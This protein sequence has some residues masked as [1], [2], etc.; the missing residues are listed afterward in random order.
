MGKNSRFDIFYF[1]HK[2]IRSA[3]AQLQFRAG[4]LDFSVDEFLS[5][6]AEELHSLWRLLHLHA[7]G[8]DAFVMPFLKIA[9]EGV[10]NSLE[11]DH[12]TFLPIMDTIEAEID[13]IR[14]LE[15][16]ERLTKNISFNQDLNDF[17]SRYFA[18]LQQEELLAMPELWDA[19]SDEE[20]IEMQM[21]FPSITP[22]EVTAYFL[23]YLFPSLNPYERVNYLKLVH[24]KAPE[25]VFTMFTKVA[26][27][28]LEKPDWELLKARI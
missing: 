9:N 27:D 3:L 24:A 2:A 25:Q 17:I 20:L 22:P 8:E 1:P 7:E 21:K 10:F 16:S 6:F 11:K 26:Q 12:E 15:P 5:G 13:L 23:K 28:S 4:S 18:H 19:H 14:S